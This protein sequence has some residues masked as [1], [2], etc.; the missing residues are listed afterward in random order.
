MSTTKIAVIGGDRRQGTVAAMLAEE[1]FE[2][3]VYALDGIDSGEAV[4][5]G[6]LE[7]ALSGAAAVVLP[8]PV[9]R[10]G[11]RV[12][13]PGVKDAPTL[14]AIERMA[15]KDTLIMGGM[16]NGD[17][18][19]AHTVRD[20]YARE[21]LVLYNT[22]P[23]AE[24]ALAIAMNELPTT[25]HGTHT[26]VMG[27]GRV[28]KALCRLLKGFGADVVVATRNPT[29]RAMC[30]ILG[31]STLEYSAL[32]ESIGDFGLIFNTV[33]KVLLTEGLLQ[34]VGDGV[35]VIDLATHPGGVDA[36]AAKALGK[37]LIWALSL[38]GKVAPVTAGEYIHKAIKGIL[39]EEGVIK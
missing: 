35:P 19:A 28:G 6:D 14:L 23:T 27:F 25:I 30:E 29:E 12:N 26:L 13:A 37:K 8:L 18:F 7:G 39:K 2:C 9:S 20:Y 33:P 34:K 21:D 15:D 1:G 16:I 36:E 11:K 10:D 38:P 5:A 32:D 3:A 17:D 22:L 31:I 24:G 4:K